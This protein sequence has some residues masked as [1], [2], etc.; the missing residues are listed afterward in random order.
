MAEI[1]AVMVKE[2]RETTGLGMMECKKALAEAEGDLKKAEELLRIKGGARAS[3]MAGR[4]AA[5]G[6]VS[7]DISADG[8]TGALVEVNCETDFVAKDENFAGFVKAVAAT[9]TKADPA[10]LD[11]LAATQGSDGQTIEAA[12]RGLI[13]KIGENISVR[14]FVRMSATGR[15]A[16]Y[17]HGR[18]IGVLLDYEGGDENLGKDLAMHIAASKPIHVSAQE[19]PAA[20]IAKER[21]IY[22]AQEKDSGKPAHIIAKIID[23][24]VA[25]YL[26][27][28][29]LLGQPFVKNPDETVAKLLQA[30]GA[31]VHAFHMYIV[32]EGLEK[33]KDDFVAAVMAQAGHA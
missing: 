19:V 4:V 20:V 12:R 14:R 31:K 8:R 2:L 23:G 29:T 6:A 16:C 17:V 21:E 7:V 27:E 3:K 28:V 24:R 10:D 13:M 33:K 30:K 26:A 15:L 18:K 11:A 9:V 22:A 1:T 5:E 25:K 32:G